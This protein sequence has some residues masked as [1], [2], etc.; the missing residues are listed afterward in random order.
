LREV[1]SLIGG[2][3]KET[4]IHQEQPLAIRSS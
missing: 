4:D 1:T 2:G 3:E